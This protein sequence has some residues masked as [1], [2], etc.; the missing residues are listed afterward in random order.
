MTTRPSDPDGWYDPEG[1]ERD[2]MSN[3][4]ASL[5]SPVHEQ[6]DRIAE[7]EAERTTNATLTIA[8]QLLIAELEAKIARLTERVAYF[9]R[10][11]QDSVS[12]T[13]A[14]ENVET[15]K[16]E[17]ARLTAALQL[18]ADLSR[19]ES[20]AYRSEDHGPGKKPIR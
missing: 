10:E 16:A 1:T 6:K 12:R 19:G 11:Y 2:D 4:S 5:R 7:L 9:E 3:I 17:I 8:L 13:E 20:L 15:A 14:I 18:P